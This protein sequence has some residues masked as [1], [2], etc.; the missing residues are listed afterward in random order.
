MVE[1]PAMLNKL[2]RHKCRDVKSAADLPA[3]KLL[4]M[5]STDPLDVISKLR[6]QIH[7]Q[8]LLPQKYSVVDI[9]ITTENDALAI[10]LL[11]KQTRE[12]TLRRIVV[13]PKK[14]G[15]VPPESTLSNA[16]EGSD[17]L[18]WIKKS[19]LILTVE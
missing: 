12:S 15:L 6:I 2:F 11:D 17:L 1:L 3:I 19:D 10:S 14:L 16:N 9:S 8:N 4:F 5:H 18:D 13:N 7:K